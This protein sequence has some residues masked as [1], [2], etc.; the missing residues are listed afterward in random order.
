[1][2]EAGRNETGRAIA[3]WWRVLHPNEEGRRGDRA[4][5]ARLRRAAT[6]NEV[7]VVPEA[8]R[9]HGIVCKA[10]ERERLSERES[11]SVAVL[12]GVLAVVKPA[13][14]TNYTSFAAMLG[15][16]ADGRPPRADERPLFSPTRFASLIRTEDAEERLRHLRRAVAVSRGASFDV[17]RFADDI[18]RW[19]DVT[20]R[21]WIFEYYQQGR[22]APETDSPDSEEDTAQ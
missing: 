13:A 4:T 17:A 9:L 19:N 12:A 7:I 14:R 16:T 10:L 2:K 20:R 6:P 11:E 5:A 1:M 18:L 8:I 21:R 3:A 22:A 15:K